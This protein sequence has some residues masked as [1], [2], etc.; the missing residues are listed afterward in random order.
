MN[1]SAYFLSVKVII[2]GL[3][4]YTYLC[5][6][7]GCTAD[8]AKKII[9]EYS[10]IHKCIVGYLYNYCVVCPLAC[11]CLYVH[12]CLSEF[13]EFSIN[14]E[15]W[16]IELWSYLELQDLFRTFGISIG[17]CGKLKAGFNASIL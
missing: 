4:Q 17:T 7:T 8:N 12:V 16:D 2:M 5:R 6:N 1:I 3:T 9:I 14:W 10:L 15:Y 13:V 11:S